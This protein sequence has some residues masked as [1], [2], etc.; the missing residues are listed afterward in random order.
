MRRKMISALFL[1]FIILASLMFSG[2]F[3]SMVEGMESSSLTD[4]NIENIFS[5]LD[6]DGDGNIN[7][8]DFKEILATNPELA[9]L[10]KQKLPDNDESTSNE[11]TS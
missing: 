2:V 10:L 7:K 5:T 11:P 3:S 1:L 8:E 4:K 6:K 9:Q